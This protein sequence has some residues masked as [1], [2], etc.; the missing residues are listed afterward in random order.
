MYIATL[1][2]LFGMLGHCVDGMH[3]TLQNA[4]KS[5]F[6][7]AKNVCRLEQE[8]NDVTDVFDCQELSCFDRLHAGTECLFPRVLAGLEG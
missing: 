8:I 5:D 3:V 6:L 1:Y 7:Q 4:Q 2:G